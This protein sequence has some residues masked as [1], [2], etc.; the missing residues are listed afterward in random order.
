MSDKRRRLIGPLS[1]ME[2]IVCEI[3][4]DGLVVD[5]FE[6]QVAVNAIEYTIIKAMEKT[7]NNE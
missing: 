6:M 5:D 1:R 2:K 3:V 7:R 4:D